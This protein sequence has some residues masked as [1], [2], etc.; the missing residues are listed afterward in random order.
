MAIDARMGEEE[1][2]E[3]QKK[4]TRSRSPNVGNRRSYGGRRTEPKT[5]EIVQGRG[6]ASFDILSVLILTKLNKRFTYS[7]LCKKK[8][9]IPTTRNPTHN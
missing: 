7:L 8:K 9:K 1:Q 6:K 5:E 2:K 4:G 3:K